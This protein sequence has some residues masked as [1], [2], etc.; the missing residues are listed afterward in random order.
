MV[1]FGL[2]WSGRVKRI[3]QF[4]KNYTTFF[5]NVNPFDKSG[6]PLVISIQKCV[7]IRVKENK[8]LYGGVLDVHRTGK[9]AA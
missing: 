9:A 5:T 8:G 1:S 7:F 4:L 3:K 2:E 6:R